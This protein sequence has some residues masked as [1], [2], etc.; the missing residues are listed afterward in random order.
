[1]Q[2]DKHKPKDKEERILVLAVD[3]DNDLYRKT[4]ISGPLIGRVQNLNGASQLALADPQDTDANTMFEAV[5]IY[6]EL[7]KD[8]YTVNVATITGSEKEGYDADREIARQL[9]LVLESTKSDGC[10]FVTDGASDM[11]ILPIVQSRIKINSTKT[12]KLKQAENLENTYFTLIEKLKE[13]HYARIVFG[14]PAILILLFAISYLLGAGWEPPVALIGLYLLLKGFGL[15][16]AFID[17]FKGFGFS[18]ERM[19]FAFYL[20]SMIFLAISVFIGVDNYYN[21][22]SISNNISVSIAYGLQGFLILV[23][24]VMF[25][26]LIGR[27]IDVRSSKYMFR[28]FKYGMYLGSSIIVWI[29]SY[30]FLSWIIGQIY[31]GQFFNYT[32]LVIA[33]GIV[34]SYSIS[35]L[36]RRVIGSKRLKN[37]LVVNELGALIGKVGG[38]N[39]KKGRFVINTSF[40]NPINYSVDRIVE[41]SDKVVIK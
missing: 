18:I 29:L 19:S 31:F 12:V 41:I 2:Q 9:E 23:P 32:L 7:K 24:I 39:L 15:E 8:G 3:I 30:S 33:I 22:M 36:R 26:Y 5:K 35:F 28:S 6:D 16:D 17:S 40:G 27:I 34:V 13:P 11:R 25:L 20:S 21:Q 4:N 10:V 38:V 1:V 14:I 37:K